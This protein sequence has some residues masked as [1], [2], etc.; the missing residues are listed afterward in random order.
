MKHFSQESSLF[1]PELPQAL[2]ASKFNISS[3]Y[4]VTI[5]FPD[6]NSD[7]EL[8]ENY[9]SIMD[10]IQLKLSQC[11]EGITTMMSTGIYNPGHCLMRENTL[12]VQLLINDETF[13]DIFPQI[14]DIAIDFKL[15]T[16]QELMLLTISPSQKLTL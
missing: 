5:Y 2:L 14:E 1:A 8:I 11:C 12:M 6:K 4:T 13:P 3:C 16:R 9:E 15:R 10:N 7:G